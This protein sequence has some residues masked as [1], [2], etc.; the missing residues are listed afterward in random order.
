MTEMTPETLKKIGDAV[1]VLLGDGPVSNTD[2]H[3]HASAWEA[4]LKRAGR[5]E[6]LLRQRDAMMRSD[7]VSAADWGRFDAEVEA[8]LAAEEKP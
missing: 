4:D 8:A 2:I 6:M 5:F 7:Q 1:D 3:A